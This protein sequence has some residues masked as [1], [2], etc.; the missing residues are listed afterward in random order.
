VEQHLMNFYFIFFK[1]N[2]YIYKYCCNVRHI[3]IH[4]AE[5]LI[6]DH[7]HFEVVSAI[8]KLRKYKSLRSDEILAELIEA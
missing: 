6:P 7:S 1:I 4:T 8:A 3:E 2:K 5:P